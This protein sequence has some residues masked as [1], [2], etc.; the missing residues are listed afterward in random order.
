[1]PILRKISGIQS[2][3]RLITRNTERIEPKE[4]ELQKSNVIPFPAPNNIKVINFRIKDS[5]CLATGWKDQTPF[6]NTLAKVFYIDGEKKPFWIVTW[7]K[8]DAAIPGKEGVPKKSLL[9]SYIRNPDSKSETVLQTFEQVL[10][11]TFFSA[12]RFIAEHNE[13]QYGLEIMYGKGWAMALNKDTSIEIAHNTVDFFL[14]AIRDHDTNLANKMKQYFKGAFA[15][16]IAHKRRS[17]FIAENDTGQEIAS[18]A[19]EL[20]ACGGDNPISDEKFEFAINNPTASYPQDMFA[21]LKVLE[22]KF[23]SNKACLYKPKNFTVKELNKAM[24]SIPEKKRESVLKQIAKEILYSSPVELLKTAARV[25]RAP[26]S[27]ASAK[28]GTYSGGPR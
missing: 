16:E 11:D 14:K 7:I 10:I 5:S 27:A 1:M 12:K 21:T 25:D 3:S 4:K 2:G 19:I 23:I 9:Y 17:E 24:K 22:Q 20:L 8:Q 18:H 13:I 6:M 28:T 26:A 15:H